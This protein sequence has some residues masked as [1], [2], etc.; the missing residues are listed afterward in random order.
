M[1][2]IADR[3]QRVGMSPTVKISGKAKAMKAEGIDVLNLSVGE[4]DFPTPQNIKEAGIRAIEN[5]QT[6][7]TANSGMPELKKAIIGRI[8][9]DHGVRYEQN[10]IIVSS[11]AKNAL[12]NLCI[13]LLNKGEEAI[14]PIPYWVSYPQMVNLAEGKPVYIHT[15]EE[16]GF[17]LTPEQ[18]TRAINSNTK[19]IFFNNPSNP[20]G[21]VYEK[22]ELEAL[23]N[24]AVDRN[25]VIIADEIYE[26]LVYDGLRF[27][28]I[29]SL[30]E[31][32]RERTVI[33][34]GVSK[35]YAMT[36]WRLGFAAGPSELIAAMDK[37][38]SHNTSNASTISQIAAIE[39]YNGPQ[40]EIGTMLSEFQR[41]RDYMHHRLTQIPNISCYKAQGAFYLFPN[42][43]HYYDY[44]HAG[45]RVRDSNGMALYLL[46]EARVAVVPGDAFGADQF[47]RL[48][49]ATS[50]ET[51]EQAMDRIEE[52]MAK[53]KP[54]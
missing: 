44:Q 39:A 24:I 21:T 26:K 48:S 7:Y 8:Y 4:P 32:V 29:A 28:S 2:M 25:L 9:H 15:Q 43:S 23:I 49:Y 53:L 45:T 52:A 11:G 36:G 50:M 17:R 22:E 18:L 19:A 6:K 5:N 31:Q 42:F 38:Q 1:S 46:D 41:R 12:F 30:G 14:I 13:A 37:V 20:S 51:I 16:N 40:D 34:N 47:I 35:A 27:E 10:E 3:I 54:V 33:I